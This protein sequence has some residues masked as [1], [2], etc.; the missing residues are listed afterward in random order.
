MRRK[1][2]KQG[3]NGNTIY[4]PKKWIDSNKLSA[5]DF[6]DVEEDGNNLIISA[7]EVKFFERE[8]NLEIKSSDYHTYRSIIG[9]LYRLGYTKITVALEGSANINMLNK[10]V[11]SI[12]GYEIVDVSKN[13]C[14]IR[15]LYESEGADL[16]KYVQSMIS[17]SKTMQDSVLNAMR[18]GNF[19]IEDELFQYRAMT[20]RQRDLVARM[21]VQK[22]S[23]DDFSYYQIA[24][25]LW[26]VTRSFYTMFKNMERKKY[27][28]ETL[29][30][31][32][33]VMDH[34][35]ETFRKLKDK[36]IHSRHTKYVK[37]RN[38]TCAFI[39]TKKDPLINAFLVNTLMSIYS[40]ES[41]LVALS[42]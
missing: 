14:V 36:D 7:N 21:V 32:Q 29:K 9:G 12:S 18:S 28:A 34:F 19:E 20:L 3:L 27:N 6:V 25:S 41:A 2:I 11:N 22:K 16:R 42:I 24:Y 40:A 26:N 30:N 1:I 5:G 33:D 38:K 15:S 35:D 13:V 17:I 10:I 23:V 37:L 39:N 4:L 8:T 31:V